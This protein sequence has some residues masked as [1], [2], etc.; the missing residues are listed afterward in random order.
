MNARR[1]GIAARAAPTVKVPSSAGVKQ[2][3]SFGPTDAAARLWV[4]AVGVR[5]GG[6]RAEPRDIQ[7]LQ[8]SGIC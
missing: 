5:L 3:M 6:Q 4:R 7:G 2:A 1:R 8:S